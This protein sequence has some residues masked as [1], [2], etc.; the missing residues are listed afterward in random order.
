M[1]NFLYLYLTLILCISCKDEVLPKPKGYL[2]L[3]YPKQ[4]YK[5]IDLKR[6]Y[7]FKV[8][9]NAT[10]KDDKNNW[11]K[12]QYPAL[13]ASVDITYRPV[14]NNLRLL[15]SESE[16]L[17]FEHTVKADK[18]SS[19]NFTHPEKNMFGSMYQI[20]GNS[21]SQIQF[22]LTD[23]TKHFIKGS[24]FF[25]SKPNYDS[26]LPAVNYI[27]KDILKLIETAEWVN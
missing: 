5:F 6:P 15:L 10:V 13:R 19:Q 11:V 14:E 2:N 12:I 17:V 18:I 26:I 3:K 16:K 7:T 9:N 4:T 27:K 8:A 23:S 20:S 24:L 21:A 22:H 1:R 25:Y